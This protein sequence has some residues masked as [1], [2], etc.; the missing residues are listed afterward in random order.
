M[1]VA[2]KAS[3]IGRKPPFTA[4]GSWTVACVMAGNSW[5]RSKQVTVRRYI[6]VLAVLVLLLPLGAWVEAVPLW[7]F[8]LLDAQS[9]PA[10]ESAMS[11]PMFL[12]VFATVMAL[13]A[14]QLRRRRPSAE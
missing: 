4:A 9:V 8:G 1:A 2:P 14:R 13:S 3:N 6:Q 12:V 10:A 7:E 11:E 5:L